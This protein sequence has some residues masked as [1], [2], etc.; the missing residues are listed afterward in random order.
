[1]LRIS[2]TLIILFAATVALSG[3]AN[4]KIWGGNIIT[5]DEDPEVEKGMEQHKR[6]LEQVG[7]YHDTKL[8]AYVE[9]VGAKIASVSDRPN[10]QWHFTVLDLATPNA[11]ATQGGYIYITRGMLTLLQS[12]TEL[13]AILAHET[14][15]I[16]ARDTPNAERVGN[17]MGIG[18]LGALIAA[19]ALI[20]FPQVAAAPAAAGMASISRKHELNADKL[21]T[22]Y[23]RRAGYPP[24][25]M[26]TT[27]TLLTDMEAYERDQQK[28]AGRNPSGWWHR[29]YASHP[30]AEE[31]EEKISAAVSSSSKKLE[32]TTGPQ[33][34]FLSYLNGLEV[35]SSKYQGIAY[36]NARYFADLQLAIEVPDGWIAQLNIKRDELWLVQPEKNARIKIE[37][38]A[39]IDVNDPCKWLGYQPVTD[40]KPIRNQAL[41]SCTG[42]TRK[43]RRTLL[44]G[45]KEEIFRAGVI[46]H[47]KGSG[48]GYLFNGYAEQK[49]FAEID[50]IFLRITGSIE[51]LPP[52]RK[53][54]KPPTL[55]IRPAKKGDTFASLARN[56]RLIE[57]NPES[58]LRLVNRSYP[59]GEPQPGELIKI[60]E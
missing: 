32:Q 37:K 21:G 41:P 6:I 34:D 13:A 44:G 53:I 22:E 55:H 5:F 11:F 56:S 9:T 17:I 60:I 28:A 7:A 46:A 18:V 27:M 12:E 10:L 49:N 57:K 15:H 19:P 25:S 29:V 50:P 24:E 40:T 58:M 36:G 52:D 42:L 59:S 31:R 23:L 48:L 38:S 35:G 16:C 47:S 26:V 14:A 39:S 43:W 2:E 30:T 8:S 1:M 51:H 45:D 54:P 4:E 3:C 33:S 20:L